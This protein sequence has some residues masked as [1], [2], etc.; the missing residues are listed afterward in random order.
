AVSRLHVERVCHS[1]P[2]RDVFSSCRRPCE[3]PPVALWLGAHS[4]FR[5]AEDVLAQRGLA[6][7]FPRHDI[8]GCDRWSSDSIHRFVARFSR[9]PH[10]E[11]CRLAGRIVREVPGRV[12]SRFSAVLRGMQPLLPALL[13]DPSSFVGPCFPR[14]NTPAP[15]WCRGNRTPSPA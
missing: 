11:R 2:P 13:C 12:M 10:A 3:I 9:P 5:W 8:P 6:G 14:T 15:V 4:D 1:W 7:A